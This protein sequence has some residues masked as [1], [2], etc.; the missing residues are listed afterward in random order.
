MHSLFNNPPPNLYICSYLEKNREWF[1]HIFHKGFGHPVFFCYLTKVP[2]LLQFGW[3]QES[4]LGGRWGLTVKRYVQMYIH[5]YIC[6]CVCIDVMGWVFL[7]Q[8]NRTVPSSTFTLQSQ[9]ST[10]FPSVTYPDQHESSSSWPHL[11]FQVLCSSA[12][13]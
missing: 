12:H 10:N 4:G 1:S 7:V 5:I 2:F 13:T 6:M 9:T 8:I 11:I 3:M